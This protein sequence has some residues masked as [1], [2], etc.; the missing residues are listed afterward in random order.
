VSKCFLELWVGLVLPAQPNQMKLKSDSVDCPLNLPNCLMGS[1]GPERLDDNPQVVI[2]PLK[3][4]LRDLISLEVGP[5]CPGHPSLSVD[6]RLEFPVDKDVV[7]SPRFCGR[8][9]PRVRV[10]PGS[11]PIPM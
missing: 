2:E 6:K 4:R 7:L 8:C 5:G 1:C 11:E 9:F 3:P 10:A